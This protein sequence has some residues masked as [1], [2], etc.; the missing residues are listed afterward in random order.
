MI[1]LL[2]KINI[3]KG[4]RYALYMLLSLIAQEM[5]LGQFRVAGVAPM[6]LPA[7]A[8]AMGMFKGAV[9]GP[10]FSMILGIFADMT[11]IE[12]TIAFTVFFPLVSFAA[13]FVSEF[14]INR[15]FFAY[16]GVS[17]VALLATAVFQMV[18]T[19]AGDA[20]SFVMLSTVILQAV[21]SMPAAVLA[22]FP[23]AK[24]IQ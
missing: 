5:V 7:V 16:M 6:I 12:N 14:Y 2:E 8:V 10:I 18:K 21:L 17:L 11:F 1:E 15:S 22:Y 9:Y 4:M 20:F 23:P 3:R 19:M 13:A 24:W